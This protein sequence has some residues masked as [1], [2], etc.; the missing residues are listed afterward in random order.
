MFGTDKGVGCFGGRLL[1]QQD[2][3]H[4]TWHLNLERGMG[5]S[6]GFEEAVEDEMLWNFILLRYL[7]DFDDGGE[8][9]KVRCCFLLLVFRVHIN[10]RSLHLGIDPF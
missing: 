2:I 9:Y 6:E 4:Q 7:Q 1:T 5:F 3:S 8:V 10:I